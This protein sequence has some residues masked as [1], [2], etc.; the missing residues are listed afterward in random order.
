MQIDKSYCLFF[1]VSAEELTKPPA[2]V[3]QQVVDS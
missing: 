3:V 1:P 2:T